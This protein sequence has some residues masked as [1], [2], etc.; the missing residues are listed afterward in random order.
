MCISLTVEFVRLEP[1]PA[2]VTSA[3]RRA[4]RRRTLL[5]TTT[6]MPLCPMSY[7]YIE[8]STDLHAMSG[9]A[10]ASQAVVLRRQHYYRTRTRTRNV[11]R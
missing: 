7:R 2:A 4:H 6:L 1:I 5:A 11:P 10:S 3:N 8:E 9:N